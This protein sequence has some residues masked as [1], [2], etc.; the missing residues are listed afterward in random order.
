[1]GREKSINALLAKAE[2]QIAQIEKEYRNS[3]HVQA[4]DPALRVDIKN[5]CENIRSVLDYI[6]RDIR[7]RYCPNASANARFYFPILPDQNT[8]D[9]R[10][11]EWFLG[12]RQAAPKVIAALQACQPFQPDYEWLGQFNQVNNENKHGD[13]V[14]Q[15]R[16]ESVRTT[17][18]GQGG[19]QVSWGPGVTF[20]SGV[21]IMG[22]PVDPRTQLPVPDPSI[23]VERVV[24]RFSVRWSWR[25]SPGVAKVGACRCSTD[26]SQYSTAVV[27]AG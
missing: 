5:A 16:T 1:M 24:G 3:L 17:V 21:S 13:L 8:F 25:L 26:R 22:V 20:G 12:L 4:I 10:V 7:G 14:E 11:D 15:T 18:T 6:A 9:K 2:Q 23:R 27:N 19:G